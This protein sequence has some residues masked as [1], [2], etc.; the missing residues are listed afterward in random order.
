MFSCFC[1][2]VLEGYGLTENFAG[3]FITVYDETQFG[4]VGRPLACN[5]VKLVDVPEMNYYGKN[6][7]GEI[8]IRGANVFKGYYK[9]PEKT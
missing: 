7:T 5:E 2:K 6:G 4:H 1:C 3:A 9:D 8:L